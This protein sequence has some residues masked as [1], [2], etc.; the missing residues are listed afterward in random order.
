MKKE[1]MSNGEVRD[2]PQKK[3]SKHFLEKLEATTSAVDFYN[4]KD[5]ILKRLRGAQEE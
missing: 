5:E 3:L 1:A 4:Q 2:V